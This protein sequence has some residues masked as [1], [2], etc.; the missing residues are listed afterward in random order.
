MN[1]TSVLHNANWAA[2]RRLQELCIVT[3]PS[4]SG[5][6]MASLPIELPLCTLRHW[7]SRRS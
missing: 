6:W 5:G 1:A 2:K 7:P 4:R 3:S